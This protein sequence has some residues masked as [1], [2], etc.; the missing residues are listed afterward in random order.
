MC[1][2]RGFGECLFY[3]PSF[4]TLYLRLPGIIFVSQSVDHSFGDVIVSF[5]GF[6]LA[7]I[8]SYLVHA[9]RVK[10]ECFVGNILEKCEHQAVY[11]EPFFEDTLWHSTHSDN[12]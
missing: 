10:G 7:S 3:I 4:G 1:R 2:Q 9:S 5:V 8:C 12:E 11:N 6:F